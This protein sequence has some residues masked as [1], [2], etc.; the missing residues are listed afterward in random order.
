MK[1]F[2]ATF[3]LPLRSGLSHGL[4]NIPVPKSDMTRIFH[5]NGVFY[6]VLL[7]VKGRLRQRG[8]FS[9]SAE[10]PSCILIMYVFI[11]LFCFVCLYVR[12]FNY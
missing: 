12:L 10:L 5:G 2:G 8:H 4:H 3:G 1:D 7:P 11:S 9:I 6:F